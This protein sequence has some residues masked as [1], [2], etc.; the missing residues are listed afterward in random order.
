MT[1]FLPQPELAPPGI[2][3][4]PTPARTRLDNGIEVVVYQLPG[5]HVASDPPGAGH[6]AERRGPRDRGRGHHL[7]AGAGRGQPAARRRGVRRAAGDRGRRLRHRGRAGRAAGGP[8]CAG[9][10]PRP[11]AGAVRRGGPRAVAGRP[12]RQPAR[13]AAAG[14]D[15]AGPGQL[16]PGGE[17]RVPLGGLR[18]GRPGVADERRRAGRPSARSRPRRVAAFHA[19]HFGPGAVDVDLG[20]RLPDRSGRAGR[21]LPRLAGATRSSGAS[22][23]SRPRRRHAADAADRPARAR[24]RPTCGS[25]ASGSTGSTRAGPTSPW[26]ATPWAGR[27]CPG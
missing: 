24:C 7:R 16:G 4:F 6:P 14:R 8:R 9:L 1:D 2:W 11:R 22:P 27:S 23:R 17:H 15:R 19:D 3:S 13:P 18:P 12:R 5:Q 20:R 25:A 21:A 10:A 26:P